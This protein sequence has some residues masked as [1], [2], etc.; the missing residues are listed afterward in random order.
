DH[1]GVFRA[2]YVS[3]HAERLDLWIRSEQRHLPVET[4]TKTSIWDLAENL[5]RDGVLAME[6]AI[7]EPLMAAR[8]DYLGKHDI[9]SLLLAPIFIDGGFHGVISFSTIG[10]SHKW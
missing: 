5:D 2:D 6:D 8:F 9:R 7:A 10:R 4:E 1:A 3:K